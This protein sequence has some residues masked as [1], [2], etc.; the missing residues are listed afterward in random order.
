MVTHLGINSIQV[1]NVLSKNRLHKYTIIGDKQLQKKRR[2]RLW[3]AQCTSRQKYCVTCV[4]GKN[5][6]RTFYIASFESFQ[7][8]RNF[9][10]VKTKLKKVYS[11]AAT[12]SI[13]LLQRQYWFCQ[14]TVYSKPYKYSIFNIDFSKLYLHLLVLFP[15]KDYVSYKKKLA[16]F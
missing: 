16:S 14:R 5:D 13:P 9:F 1:K 6:S 8:N 4:A 12:K 2:W 3:T 15:I 11:T 10:G 7:P